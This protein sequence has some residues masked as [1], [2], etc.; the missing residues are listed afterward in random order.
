VRQNSY[1]LDRLVRESGTGPLTAGRPP[2]AGELSLLSHLALACL[3]DGSMRIGDIT[4]PCAE[5]PKLLV[6]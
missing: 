6:R 3:P 2:L 1:V 4:M 5:T